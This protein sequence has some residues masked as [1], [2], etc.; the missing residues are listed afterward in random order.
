MDVSDSIKSYIGR[1]V[2]DLLTPSLILNKPVLERNTE[3]LHKDVKE[4]GIA[5]RPHVKTL[6]VCLLF[7]IFGGFPTITV[8]IKY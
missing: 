2:R 3:L 4:L 1:S 6:K 5:F 7:V 8:K